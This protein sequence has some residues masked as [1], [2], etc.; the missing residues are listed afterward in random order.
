MSSIILVLNLI[1]FKLSCVYVYT[2][3]NNKYKFVIKSVL[4][5]I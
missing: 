2:L 5:I 3:I 1:I 4:K